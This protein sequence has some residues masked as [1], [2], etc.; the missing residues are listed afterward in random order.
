MSDIL[1][2]RQFIFFIY[3][4]PPVGGS[5]ENQ[6]ASAPWRIGVKKIYFLNVVKILGTTYYN[7]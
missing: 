5:E 7:Q 4:A 3:P 6:L 2:S 1:L